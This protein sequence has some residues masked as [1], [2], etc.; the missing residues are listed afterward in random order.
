MTIKQKYIVLEVIKNVPA[1]PGRHLLE[2][3]DDLRYFGLKTVLRGDVE[4][5]CKSQREY[6]MWTQG[7]S[8][9]LVVAAERRFRM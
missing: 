2:G 5:E 3:G 6:E 8:R 1:W 9:L 7:V 4:F